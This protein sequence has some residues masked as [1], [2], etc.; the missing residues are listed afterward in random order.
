MPSQHESPGNSS[1]LLW[2][3]RIERD[4]GE[5]G[6]LFLPALLTAPAVVHVNSSPL[7]WY[8]NLRRLFFGGLKSAR[9][10]RLLFTRERVNMFLT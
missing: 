8:S 3:V 5:F 1:S 2:D 9:D 10:K 4:S 7:I 6:V